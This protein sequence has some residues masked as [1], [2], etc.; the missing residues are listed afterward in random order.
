MPI[1]TFANPTT[2][3]RDDLMDSNCIFCKIV[4]GQIPCHKL[5]ED[6]RVLACL[7]LGPLSV[8]HALVIPKH[9]AVTLDELP[10]EDA[11]AIGTVLPRL[12]KAVSKVTG[13]EAYNVLQ[14]NG[15]PAGQ[16]VM[17]VHFHLIPKP[18][19]ASPGSGL[20]IGWPAGTLDQDVA[21]DLVEKITDSLD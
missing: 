20:G 2:I 19:P 9:H 12:A 13:T 1:H 11:A 15:E 8:G 21:A 5:Y 4:A 7:D 10:S 17:H 6:D 16:V 18:T 3:M 14:N